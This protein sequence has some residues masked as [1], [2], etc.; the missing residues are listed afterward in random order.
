[1]KKN[2]FLIALLCLVS[3][4]CTTKKP[5]NKSYGQKGTEKI[6]SKAFTITL[7]NTSTSDLYGCLFYYAKENLE[8]RWSWHKSEVV[9]IRP[10]SSA[11]IS[12]TVSSRSKSDL[13]DVQSCLSVFNNKD[14]A[15]MAI[16]ELLSDEKRIDLG[17]L[18]PLNNKSIKIS[19]ETYGFKTNKISYSIVE[20]TNSETQHELSFSV[21]NSIGKNIY[22]TGF[23]YEHFN[24]HPQWDFEKLP[25]VFFPHNASAKV[26]IPT[27]SNRYNWEN[28]H[29]YLALFDEDQKQEA[30]FSIY[31]SLDPSNKVN[32][33]AL[34]KIN[35]QTIILEPKTYGILTGFA[36]EYPEIE[37]AIKPPRTLSEVL[38]KHHHKR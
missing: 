16:I 11:K 21:V 37:F 18:L 3:S 20:Q 28:I 19:P 14:D 10:Q 27:E 26:T 29:G 8:N 38:K 31:E 5:I 35:K 25:V 13:E 23:I 36:E 33:E 17:K 9:N 1:M 32:L 6:S 24:A 4:G 2:F 7:E 30:D 22:L 12:I 15:E 34:V